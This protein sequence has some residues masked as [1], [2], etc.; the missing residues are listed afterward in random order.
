MK[1]SDQTKTET[2][3]I[4]LLLDFN[5][6]STLGQRNHAACLLKCVFLLTNASA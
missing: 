4:R 3:M 5:N 6:E 1:D 2:L